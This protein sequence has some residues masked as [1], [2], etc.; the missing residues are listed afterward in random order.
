MGSFYKH[1]AEG[2][3]KDQSLRE[4]KLS[5][6]EKNKENG[7]SHPYYWC[8]YIIQGNTQAL[9][10]TAKWRWYLFGGIVLLLIFIGI[11]RLLQLF[12]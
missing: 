4:A 2:K 6:L 12:K 11:N 5:F 3:T 9:V 7:L 10:K 8:G 1:L